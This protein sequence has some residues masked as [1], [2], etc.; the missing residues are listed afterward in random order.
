[1]IA[2]RTSNAERKAMHGVYHQ[3]RASGSGSCT[4]GSAARLSVKESCNMLVAKLDVQHQ[5]EL[6]PCFIITKYY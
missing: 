5:H 1:M 6:R 2:A 4:R 3:A